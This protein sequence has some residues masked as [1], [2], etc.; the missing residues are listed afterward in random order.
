[1]DKKVQRMEELIERSIDSVTMHPTFLLAVSTVINANS[2]RKIWLRKTIEAIWKDMEL[3]VRR[4]QEKLV[5]QIEELT[6]R[7][8]KLELDVNQQ[9]P[10]DNKN[11]ERT[12][13]QTK[14]KIKTF[15]SSA[16][17]LQ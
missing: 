14:K 13:E 1:M 12:S 9:N 8:K 7:I 16:L 3:P 10:Q 15:K 6:I 4:D 17:E 5:S 2:Y 11:R